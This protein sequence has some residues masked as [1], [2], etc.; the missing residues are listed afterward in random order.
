MDVAAVGLISIAAT[1]STGSKIRQPEVAAAA[2]TSATTPAWPGSTSER[3]SEPLELAR[4]VLA[5][6]PPSSSASTCVAS[7]R[8]TPILSETLAPPRTAT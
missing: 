2:R 5:I 1:A 7:R 4:K 3:P 6:P 8:N